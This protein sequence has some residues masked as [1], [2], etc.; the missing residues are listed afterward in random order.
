M[1]TELRDFLRLAL[2]LASAQPSEVGK[3]AGGIL[4]A[5]VLAAQATQIP[6]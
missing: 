6:Y 1:R 5:E 2:P 3:P 4:G